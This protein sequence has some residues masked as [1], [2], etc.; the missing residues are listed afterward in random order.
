MVC[1]SGGVTFVLLE[2]GGGPCCAAGFKVIR[3]RGDVFAS[4]QN[5]KNFGV[6]VLSWGLI[7]WCKADRAYPLPPAVWRGQPLRWGRKLLIFWSFVCILKFLFLMWVTKTGF[8]AFFEAPAR[9]FECL[10]L[11]LK[12]ICCVFQGQYCVCIFFL[13]YFLL[14]SRGVILFLVQ[15]QKMHRMRWTKLRVKM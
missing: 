11:H 6:L 1:F 15:V 4:S 10:Q 13:L 14:Q 12:G 2:G 3:L 9:C 7:S 5:A 8:A